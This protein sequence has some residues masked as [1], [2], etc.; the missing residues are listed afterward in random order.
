MAT[1]KKMQAEKDNG[2]WE[3]LSDQAQQ[4]V[5]VTFVLSYI[6]VLRHSGL[7]VSTLVSGSSSPG[8][9]PGWGHCV[10]FLGKTLYFHSASLHLG[11]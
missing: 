11:V 7:M 2:E 4:Q 3:S 10:V 1:L 6:L 5:C 9:S 8:L